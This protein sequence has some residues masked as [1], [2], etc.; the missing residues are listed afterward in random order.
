[1]DFDVFV[2]RLTAKLDSVLM[3]T[4]KDGEISYTGLGFNSGARTMFNY[5][6]VV[7]CELAAEN[8]KGAIE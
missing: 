4:E 2:K 1:M 3:P 5:A 6:L 7:A 8:A